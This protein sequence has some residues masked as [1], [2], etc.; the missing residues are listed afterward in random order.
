MLF[1]RVNQRELYG[2]PLR[3]P[4][5]RRQR[6]LA[7]FRDSFRG[8]RDLFPQSSGSFPQSRDSFP[9]VMDSLPEARNSYLEVRDS[10]PGSS[11]SFPESRDFFPPSPETL[12][13]NADLLRRRVGSHVRSPSV[14]RPLARLTRGDGPYSRALSSQVPVF[15]GEMR[16]VRF[17]MI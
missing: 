15:K 2:T 6:L 10:F 5:S 3:M 12:P 16:L 14:I 8:A 7:G 9:E 11:D 1:H 17:F 4:Q 13:H